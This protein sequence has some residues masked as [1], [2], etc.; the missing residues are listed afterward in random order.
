MV[1][2]KV[3]DEEWRRNFIFL[4]SRAIAFIFAESNSLNW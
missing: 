1:S 3:L 2:G 4:I